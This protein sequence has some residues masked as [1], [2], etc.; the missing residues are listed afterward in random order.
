MWLGALLKAAVNG[1]QKRFGALGR[2]PPRQRK[3]RKVWGTFQLPQQ[4][5]GRRRR[6]LHSQ[7]L[8]AFQIRSQ[9]FASSHGGRYL[10]TSTGNTPHLLT[11]AVVG[12]VPTLAANDQS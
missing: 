1:R 7:A 6:L 3:R 5:C 10:L 8:T 12:K 4:L 11:S 2:F 9:K